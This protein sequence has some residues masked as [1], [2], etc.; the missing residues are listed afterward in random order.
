[1]ENGKQDLLF[2]FQLDV[3]KQQYAM[4]FYTVTL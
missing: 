2:L 3:L 4:G 1:M